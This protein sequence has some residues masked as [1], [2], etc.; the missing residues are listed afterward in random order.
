MFSGGPARPSEAQ[1]LTQ[2]SRLWGSIDTVHG[3]LS[4]TRP[5]HIVP[6]YMSKLKM[7]GARAPSFSHVGLGLLPGWRNRNSGLPHRL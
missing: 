4:W 5:F 7:V 1:R 2:L 6:V 3:R